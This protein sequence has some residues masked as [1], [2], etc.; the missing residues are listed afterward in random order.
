MVIVAC[1][2]PGCEFKSDDLTEVL[3]CAVL[4]SHAF[5]HAAAPIFSQ[6]ANPAPDQ[7]AQVRG[8]KLERPQ[9]DVGV[10]LEQWNVFLRRWEV[11]KQGSGIDEA[12][13]PS[14]LFQ[15]ASQTLGD[16]LLKS[17][18][19]IVAEPLQDLI[20]AMRKLAVIPIA[21]VVLRTELLQMRQLRDEP[22]R[23]FAARVRGKSDTCAFTARCS[24]GS[25]VNYT[26]HMIRDT[27]L[28][29]IADS[30]IRRETLGTK[31]IL[32]CGV[33]DVV[34]LV[35]SKEM[36]RN[37]MPTLDA[38]VPAISALKRQRSFP[39]RSSPPVNSSNTP[40]TLDRSVKSQCPACHHPFS[41]FKEGP[42]GWNSKPYKIC[43]DCFRSRRRTKRQAVLPA[44]ALQSMEAS[45]VSTSHVGAITQGQDVCC[46]GIDAVDSTSVDQVD[47]HAVFPNH[48][49]AH[50]GIS[51]H[52]T[53]HVSVSL[54]LETSHP[55]RLQPQ[56]NAVGVSAIADS[57]AQTNVWSFNEFIRRG[58]PQQCLAPA[59]DLAAANLSPISVEGSF[60]ALIQGASQSGTLMSC[61]AMIYV[62]KD[63]N[64]LYLS[65][66][67]LVALGIVTSTFPLIGEHIP[68]DRFTVGPCPTLIRAMN[69]GCA[70]P[71]TNP[72]DSCTCP[73]RTAVPPRPTAL[74]FACVPENIPKMKS[75]LLNHYAAS[76]FNT[77][78]HRALHSMAGPPLEIHVDPA[79]KPIACH[80]PASIPLHWQ[81]KVY[82]DLLRDEALGILERVP[83]GEPTT[84][85]H[86]MVITRK[87]DGS[88]RRTVDL[89]PLNKFCQRETFAM[90]PPFK[91]ARRIPSGTWKTV[92]DAWN[93]YHSVPLRESD[94]HLTTFI[95]PFGRWCYTRSPQGFLSSGDGY[96]RRFSAI[97]TDFLRQ[98]RCIDD[99]VFYDN[100]LEEHWWRTID[101]LSLVGR[102]GI[103]LNQD[104]FQF[105][106]QTVDFAGF[107][108]SAS[109]VEPLPKFLDAIREFPT[110]ANIT[111]IRSWFGL[112]NQVANY[113]QLRDHLAPFKPFLSPKR[114]FEWSSELEEAFVAS[115]HA[116][117]NA[118]RH[119]VEIF[120]PSKPTC[121]R[122]DFSSRG[123][124][125]F[126]LQKHCMCSSEIPGCCS[127]GWRVTLAGSRFLSSAEQRYAPIE[128]EALAVAWGLEQTKYFTQGCD[129]LVVVTDHK[130]LIKIFGD[131]ALD[132]ITNTRLFR[133]KQR[134]LLWRFH[135][136]YLPGSSNCAADATSRHPASTSD[137]AEV[138]LSPVVMAP[139]DKEEIL[140]ASIRL[141]TCQE[142][143]IKWDK[144]AFCTANDP[145]LRDLMQAIRQGCNPGDARDVSYGQ[146]LPFFESFYIQDG[147]I[148][149]RDRVVVPPDLRAEVLKTLHAAHQ[150]V[151]TMERRARA[152]IFWPGM[153]HDINMKRAS[154]VYCNRNAPSQAAT[155]PTFSAPPS[156][157]FE[158]IFA[159]YFD[160]GGRHFLVIGDRLS[161][162]FVTTVGSHVAGAAAL[163]RLL[164]T[165][166]ATFGVP[167]ELSSDGGPE[168]RA[169]ATQNF[170]Q[171]WGVS[172]R[173]SSAYFAQSNGRAEVA[174]KTAKR[175]LMANV[176]PN[177]DINNDAFLRAMLQLRNTPDPDC[178]MSPAEIVYGHPLRDAFS[179]INRLEKFSNRYVRR[180]WREAWRAKETALRVRA[181]RMH[182]ALGAHARPLAA[183]KCGDRIFIQNQTGPHPHK[184]DKIG[185]VVEVLKFDQ[186]CV[187]IEGS[188]RVT[189]RNRRF[190]RLAPGPHYRPVNTGTFSDHDPPSSTPE[191]STPTSSDAGSS[192]S[193]LVHRPAPTPIPDEQHNRDGFSPGTF[194]ATPS[195]DTSEPLVSPD[196]PQLP[197]RR[198]TRTRGS[199]KELDPAT[200]QW[201]VKGLYC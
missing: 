41:P 2:Y 143:C 188:G 152:T 117:I 72:T 96:N 19:K 110:P 144:L 73:Q 114:K 173:V 69:D 25:D 121:L 103:V 82:E 159:D 162:V 37:A 15:C 172:H 90:E 126:L 150:G 77:C 189:R 61:R 137:I 100:N 182:D 87:H 81:Q 181:G 187:K 186:Y 153:T 30:D 95:T 47:S 131:R 170:L 183:L 46:F 105:A 155:P 4:Q 125:Y 141:D 76:T 22:F 27:L 127:M 177:G 51:E 156:T 176:S 185:I 138:R 198:S 175:L 108:V 120:D 118:I 1:A 93:G 52:P 38:D 68:P 145:S 48:D 160:Y 11:F 84:W 75:W 142:L 43:P 60:M 45:S 157:P 191:Q 122:P 167:E 78:P 154:C 89:S 29:G 106:Q 17:N 35:E 161:D 196:I 66:D 134:T 34:A 65:R 149:Y 10:S 107:R 63:V 83:D 165:Y 24:C 146:Y 174:V 31:D 116:I 70:M 54:E 79:A 91:L 9:V 32:T 49:R 147:V 18:A 98:E 58:F 86:R 20:T 115:K 200:G 113:A 92:T 132:E 57:G 71:G 135:I 59:P 53:V 101:F 201:V 130:P 111:D 94:R 97:L 192:D 21:T 164:R 16:N 193:Q 88:P 166:F 99:T 199:A 158:K 67:T 179:F 190:L 6:N 178:D 184:W 8:P 23:S 85:C 163:V 124:G 5:S 102:A 169:S 112:I 3:A 42:H 28:N 74:P 197:L 26:D 12:S 50:V 133:L 151:S 80:T 168:F 140:L 14:Q 104:K 62:S 55:G 128:G 139:E 64:T 13:A 129:T 171:T 136:A 109:S 44:P 119:G 36:A 123:I 194:G 39:P 180:S 56:F 148:M 195:L 7:A 40:V 33:N